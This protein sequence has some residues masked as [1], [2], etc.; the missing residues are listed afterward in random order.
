MMMWGP[1]AGCLPAPAHPPQ[2]PVAKHAE[3]AR[4]AAVAKEVSEAMKKVRWLVVVPVVSRR[5]S[6]YDFVLVV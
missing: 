1:D 2:A 6:S 4:Q 3:A 5:T